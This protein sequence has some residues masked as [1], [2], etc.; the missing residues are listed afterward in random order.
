MYPLSLIIFTLIKLG[1]RLHLDRRCF[2]LHRNLDGTN[3]KTKLVM[4]KNRRKQ[5]SRAWKEDKEMY[6]LGKI[7]EDEFKVL[8]SSNKCK[9]DHI[10]RLKQRERLKMKWESL[11]EEKERDSMKGDKPTSVFGQWALVPVRFKGK[12]K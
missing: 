8:K 10:A 9:K 11:K 5:T 4:K 3:K 6:K 7:V 12:M 2:F 1:L